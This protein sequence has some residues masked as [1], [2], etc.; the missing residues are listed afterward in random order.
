VGALVR[1]GRAGR[2]R[3]SARGRPR[4]LVSLVSRFI[5]GQAVMAGVI[6]LAYS[7]RNVPWLLIMLMLAVSLCLLAIMIRSGTH[8][9]WTVAVGFEAVLAVVGLYRF[10]FFGQYVGGTLL[11]L[12]T[13]GVLMHPA[14]GRAFTA[15]PLRAPQVAE[16]G[17]DELGEQ[18]PAAFG[19]GTASWGEG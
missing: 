11:S 8:T 6:G 2:T 15:A 10:I 4:P 7:R 18:P 5:L 12:I 1:S 14:V 13:F 9:A 19:E 3:R 16:A 17:F